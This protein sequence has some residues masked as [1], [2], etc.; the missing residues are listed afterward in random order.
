MTKRIIALLIAVIIPAAMIFTGCSSKQLTTQ[1]YYDQLYANFK[2]YA[3]ELKE[4]TTIQ[5]NVKTI[6][7]VQKMLNKANDTC[8]KADAVLDKFSKMNP[9]SQF[10]DKHKK[11]LSAIETEKKFISTV[12]K[13]FTSKSL[14]ELSQ[15]TNEAQS[16]FNGIPEKQQ[17][18]AVFMDLILEAKAAADKEK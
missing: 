5:T 1:E 7:D 16:V 9:P 4:I 2:E 15:Y 3:A 13:I 12:K 14:S 11:L 8:G 6:D 10:A 18:A 17:F